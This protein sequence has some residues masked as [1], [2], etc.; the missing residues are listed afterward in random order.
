MGL[1]STLLSV[2]VLVIWSGAS[3]LGQARTMGSAPPAIRGIVGSLV[4]LV[5]Y[6]WQKAL[7]YKVERDCLLAELKR[8]TVLAQET[9]TL[10]E[11]ICK[12]SEGLG[13]R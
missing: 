11:A 7:R 9:Q 4:L 10:R 1:L 2:A 12:L 6:L 8:E 3:A 13:S 5:F